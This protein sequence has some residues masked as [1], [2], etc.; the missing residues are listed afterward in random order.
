MAQAP[1]ARQSSPTSPVGT[2]RASRDVAVQDGALSDQSIYNLSEFNLYLN[3]NVINFYRFFIYLYL[4]I[5]TCQF[6][7]WR[8]AQHF[9]AQSCVSTRSSL[10]LDTAASA[11]E[12]LPTRVGLQSPRTPNLTLGIDVVVLQINFGGN[13]VRS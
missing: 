6:K 2:S 8:M 7:L 3:S 10:G 11:V 5:Y 1:R 13:F 4:I 9:Q 12:I